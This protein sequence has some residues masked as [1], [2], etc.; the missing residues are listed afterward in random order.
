MKRIL[1]TTAIVALAAMPAFAQTD[2]TDPVT[3]ETG[4]TDTMDMATPQLNA[5]DLI[6]RTVYAS[7]AD[8]APGIIVESIDAPAD[9][10]DNVGSIDDL[11]LDADGQI[12]AIVV[13]VG[14]FFGIGA[15]P[16]SVAMDDI[17]IVDEIG[18][19]GEFFVVYNGP[20]AELEDRPELDRSAVNDQGSTF[21]TADNTAVGSDEGQTEDMVT[22]VPPAPDAEGTVPADQEM[23]ATPGPDDLAPADPELGAAPGLDGMAPAD[24]DMGAAPGVDGI[25]PTDPGM[26]ADTDQPYLMG[27]ERTALTA[28]DLQGTTLHDMSGERIGSISNIIL[29]DDGQVA[30]VIVDV[31]GFLGIGAKSVA[32]AF[33]D[34]ELT[35]EEGAMSSSLRATTMITADQFETMQEWE[36]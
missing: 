23:T 24:P 18:A 15:K 31:G 17:I 4:T 13:D 25:T 6:A 21:H 2:M 35:R 30:D 33:E 5:S 14:G 19:E 36:G 29:T 10:W 28:A 8:M 20:S 12:E 16:V 26:A 3:T 1:A 9:D 27:D 7:S 22:D 32:I 11:I 34:I